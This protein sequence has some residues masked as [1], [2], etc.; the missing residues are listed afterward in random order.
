MPC[1]GYGLSSRGSSLLLSLRKATALEPLLA[2]R[3]IVHSV[4]RSMLNTPRTP[5]SLLTRCPRCVSLLTLLCLCFN[6][7]RHPCQLGRQDFFWP[8]ECLAMGPRSLF[9]VSIWSGYSRWWTWTRSDLR[10]DRCMPL[11]HVCPCVWPGEA[12]LRHCPTDLCLGDPCWLLVHFGPCGT[13]LGR[14]C[15]FLATRLVLCAAPGTVRLVLP[16]LVGPA[17]QRCLRVPLVCV[18]HAAPSRGPHYND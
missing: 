16:R 3:M 15:E 1:S 2:L 12:A 10:Q 8:R 5:R 13:T 14:S 17:K 18:L 7:P 9:V 4:W 11:G 6:L